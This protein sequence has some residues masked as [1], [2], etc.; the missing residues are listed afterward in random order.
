V[1]GWTG[2]L[3]NAGERIQLVDELGQVINEVRYA[4]EGDWTV[5]ELGPVDHSHRG[6]QWSDQTDGGGKS[7]ELI[8]TAMPNEFG[9]N[10][11]ASLVDGGTPGKANSVAADNIA[12]MILKVRHN[13]PIP[14]PIDPVT[15]TAR[16]IDESLQSAAVRLWYRVDRSVYAGANAYPQV[17]TDFIG[18]AMFDDGTNGDAAAGDGLYAARIPSQPDRAV[19]E[20]YVEAIDAAGKVRTWP[21]PSLVDGEWRQ[22]TNALYRVDATLDPDT[23]WQAGGQPLY[24]LVMTEMERAHLALIGSRSNG[25]EDSDATMNGTFISIDGTSVE[26]CYRVGIRNRGHG[27]RTGPPN[28]YHVGFARDGLWKG[29]TAISFNCRYT[30][31]QIIGSAIFRMA[32][33]AAADAAA[34]QLRING[35]NL[36][37]VGSSMYGVYVRLEAFNDDFASKHFPDDPN[38]NLYACFRDNG[39]ADLRYRG[40][41]PIRTAPVTS[42]R[43]MCRRM[44]GRT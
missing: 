4:D 16:V 15:V 32:G 26:M 9:Q 23:Y 28:N 14:G 11:A 31:V 40:P 20:F 36:A 6:W 27:T 41:T 5:R 18:L 33:I 2:W 24:Y 25:E 1:G 29:L 43:A 13:P 39:E 7:L 34:M 10:W 44:T 19:I 3:S 42:R 22:V 35:A 17:G 37:S 30:Y 8:G 38:G 21:A 12:P